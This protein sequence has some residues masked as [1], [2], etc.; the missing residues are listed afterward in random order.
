MTAPVTI[1]ELANH[2][3]TLFRRKF[4]AE[5]DAIA[6]APGRVNL[7]GEHV[8]YEGGL[9]MP[10]AIDRWLAVALR[11]TQHPVIRGASADLEAS[12]SQ[13][14]EGAA[15]DRSGAGPWVK[16]V[17]GVLNGY[18]ALGWDVAGIDIASASSVPAG[19]GLSSS[20][21][22]ETAAAVAMEQ[23]GAPEL[24]PAERARL[25]QQAEHEFAGVPC[26]IMDQLAVG[27]AR[28][29]HA[30]FLD[31]RSLACSP[32]ALPADLS[33]L[34]VDTGVRHE[35]GQS[36]YPKR[37]AEC[38]EAAKALCVDCLRDACIKDVET[39]FSGNGHAVLRHR[40][41]H[42]V[43]EI[44]RVGAF[45]EALERN[46][47]Q[48][49]RRAMAESHDSLRDL[50]EVSCNELDALVGIGREFPEVVGCRMT[51]GGFGGSV[52]MLVDAAAVGRVAEATRDAYRRLTGL[53]AGVLKVVPTAG[54]TP[55]EI[56]PETAR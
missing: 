5:P 50:Y 41:S 8:D 20:A 54:A 13:L 42:V 26:G 19:A 40:A 9:V 35:L 21:A 29:G 47:R 43:N 56:E 7:I 6:V 39:A 16:Y 51:G 53:E 11:T 15:D 1:T 48:G 36:E 52:V 38:R 12:R 24:E 2:A 28:E 37:R 4:E 49:I 55:F 23:C 17:A 3:A 33:V 22:L 34:V 18:N 27:C 46:D 31:C 10:M 44:A 45:A 25:C 32:V 14:V 30:L